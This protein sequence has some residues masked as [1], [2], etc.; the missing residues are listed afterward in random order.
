DIGATGVLGHLQRAQPDPR[1]PDAAPA[2]GA[3]VAR[4]AGPAVLRGARA[5]VPDRA[6]PGRHA[7]GRVLWPGARL[8]AAARHGQPPGGGV[9]GRVRGGR[10]GVPV[11]PGLAGRS[12]EPGAPDPV[13]CAAPAG[14]GRAA[15]GLVPVSLPGPGRV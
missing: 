4:T 10:P 5:D 15:V 14:P 7:D 12:H 8:R 13:R 9:P 11:A 3:A 2:P 1:D 6:V